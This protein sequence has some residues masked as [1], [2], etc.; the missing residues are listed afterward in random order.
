MKNNRGV[1]ND[2]NTDAEFKKE[3]FVVFDEEIAELTIN[4]FRDKMNTLSPSDGFKAGQKTFIPE[5]SYHCTFF[6]SNLEYRKDVWN[7]MS[8]F[9]GGFIDR[10]LSKY[11]LIQAN[12]FIKPPGTGYVYP[13][14][15][16]TVV[17]EAYYSSLSLWCPLQD[18]GISN[19]TMQVVPGSQKQFELYRN[20]DIYW[21]LLEIFENDG[22]ELLQSLEV[23]KGSI[24]VLDD[25]IIHG[26]PVNQA[27]ESR[28][29]FHAMLIPI[30][31]SPIFCDLD[32]RQES[33]KV[34]EV[35]DDFWQ[36]HIP[37]KKP[38]FQ[39]PVKVEPYVK[40]QYRY[41]RQK[42]VLEQF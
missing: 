40:N 38:V 42:K 13:H 20:A 18:T 22:K 10:E 3:G 29:V 19:G 31:A 4:H 36:F 15:N 27:S 37:G 26:T 30:E 5:Q 32:N 33:V 21:P 41:N 24:V 2:L 17:D 35:K 16:L 23:K 12:I 1:F 6:D 28:V 39:N 34:Y 8:E 11:K 25:S 7:L 9:F 14:Q